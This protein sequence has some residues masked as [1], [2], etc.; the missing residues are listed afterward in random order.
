[1]QTAHCGIGA[2]DAPTR[3]YRV[4]AIVPRHLCRHRNKGAREGN[5]ASVLL[6]ETALEP[7]GPQIYWRVPSGPPIRAFVFF[8][9]KK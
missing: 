2:S 7:E 8:V 4:G 6:F 1:V 5:I 9:A 3:A